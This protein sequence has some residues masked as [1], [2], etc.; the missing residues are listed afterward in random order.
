[1]TAALVL[2]GIGLVVGVLLSIARLALAAKTKDSEATVVDAI[3]A[4]LP[5]SQCAQCGY[6]GCRPYAEAVAAGERL[7][8]CPPGGPETAAALK[9]LLARD[10]E[11]A[12]LAE[13]REQ[14]ARIVE[15]DCVG[16]ALCI[17]ACPVDAIVGAPGYLHAVIRAHCTGCE[18]CV[19]VCPV[20]CIELDAVPAR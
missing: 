2:G 1:M 3:D 10:G 20:D 14:V 13:P 19:P 11:P 4:L 8:L 17:A 6:P 18:L 16:C 7:D 9:R 12:S 5:Q 15:K